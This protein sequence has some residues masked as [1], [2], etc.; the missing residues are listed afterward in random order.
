MGA[1]GLNPMSTQENDKEKYLRVDIF[2]EKHDRLTEAY[3][4]LERKIDDL[5]SDKNWFIRLVGGVLVVAIM[6]LVIRQN[7]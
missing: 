7:G 5:V 2:N 6:G 4:R 3:V 1:K